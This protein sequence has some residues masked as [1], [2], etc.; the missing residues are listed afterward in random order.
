MIR[1]SPAS[2]SELRLLREQR[3]VRRQGQI[4]VELRQLRDE[5]LQVA[6][7]ERLSSRDADL[8][9]AAL[10][11][12]ACDACDLFERQQLAPI[13]ERM[14]TAVRLLG[15]A[16][17]AAE[18]AAVGDRDAQIAQRPAEGVEHVHPR[19]P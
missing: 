18:V 2:A 6:P 4:H 12:D 16:V 15:H 1:R 8:A 3:A 9:H 7:H 5:P 19:E 14:V 11:E 10:D 13:E 17:D